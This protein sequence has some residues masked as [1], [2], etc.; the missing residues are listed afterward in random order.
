MVSRASCLSCEARH[1]RRQLPIRFPLLMLAGEDG[2]HHVERREVDAGGEV[3]GAG[4]VDEEWPAGERALEV[5]LGVLQG[6]S[7]QLDASSACGEN[8]ER[9]R[10]RTPSSLVVL[11]QMP[12]VQLAP[13]SHSTALLQPAQASPPAAKLA[14]SPAPAL[15]PA[16][17][18]LATHHAHHS[19]VRPSDEPYPRLAAQAWSRRDDEA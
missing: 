6:R 17:R 16:L 4:R 7:S 9:G 12:S 13:A 5:F 10:G 14:L 1:D 19:S 3:D 8:G 11:N 15:P 2:A 18:L